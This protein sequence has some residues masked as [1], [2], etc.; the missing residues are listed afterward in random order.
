VKKKVEAETKQKRTRKP[1]FKVSDNPAIKDVLMKMVGPHGL[2]IVEILLK[3]KKMDE[4]KL[5]SKIKLDVNF[6]R[7]LLYKLYSKKIVSYSKKRDQKKGW[8]IY[9]WEIH[10]NRILELLIVEKQRELD[11]ILEMKEKKSNEQ[12]YVCDLCAVEMDFAEAMDSSFQCFSCGS[13]L[14]HYDNEQLVRELN[15][16]VGEVKAEIVQLEKIKE[17]N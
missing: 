11:R 7:S 8:W 17:G 14:K 6:V 12:T 4:F 10:A 5:S 1:P 2:E 16:R 3:Y 15:E 13:P 9:S